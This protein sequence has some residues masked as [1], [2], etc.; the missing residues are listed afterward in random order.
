M[1]KL[2]FDVRLESGDGKTCL[3]VTRHRIICCDPYFFITNSFCS[4]LTNYTQPLTTMYLR[5]IHIIH[6]YAIHVCISPF[7][8]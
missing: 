3:M 5:L 4:C 1:N 2:V 6:K 7:I 8:H